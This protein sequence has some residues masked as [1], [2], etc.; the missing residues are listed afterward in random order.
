MYFSW[1]T[2]LWYVV[3]LG[4]DKEDRQIALLEDCNT[5]RLN[6]TRV[7]LFRNNMKEVKLTQC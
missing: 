7:N 6:W 1:G 5:E 2:R 4:Y 3:D